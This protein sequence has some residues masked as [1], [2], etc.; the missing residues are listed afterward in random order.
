VT[1]IESRR[2][3][4]LGASALSVAGNARG[5]RKIPAK[6][7]VLTFDDAAK[8]HR[9]FVAPL[10]KDLNFRATFF[11]T[12]LWMDDGEHFMTWREI[13]EIHGMGFEIG[14]HA[15]THGNFS[16]PR[17]AS[18]LAGELALTENELHK[19]GVPRPVSFAYCGNNFGPEAFH[20]LR[21][22]GYR[23]ARR[24][25][26]PEAEYGKLQVGAVFE[27]RKHHPLLIPST[28]DAYPDWT[29]DHFERVL[30]QAREG[31]AVVLQFHGVPDPTH[32]WVNT[33]PENF[34]RYM[35]YLKEHEFHALALRDLEPF[36]DLANPPRDPMEQARYP[37][38]Q[39][40]KLALAAEVE[41][42]RADMPY[43]IASM[44]AHHYT[45]TEAAVVCG[46]PENEVEY[47]PASDPPLEGRPV[48]LPYPGGRHPRIGFLEGAID[49]MRGTK[50][51]I[52]LPWD[53]ASYVVVDLPEAIFANTGLLF[54][55][56]THVPT[57]WNDRNKTIEN[58]DWRRLENGGLTSRWLLPGGIALGASIEPHERRV[59]MELFLENGGSQALT[60]IRAQVCVLL[61]AASGFNA[62]TN[63]NKVL[64]KPIAGARNG[65]RWILTSWQDC[66]RVWANPPV[67]CF[68]SDPLLPD[69]APGQTVRVRGRLWFHE[70][71]D[72]GG[73]PSVA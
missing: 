14:N 55:A 50:A 73:E 7:V 9:S 16:T 42:T 31:Q 38:P 15:W 49:P 64:Q 30:T 63:D 57:I 11:V 36:V 62:Q 39:D 34:R 33:P 5:E 46:Q 43:W 26:P 47:V 58:V 41:A 35:T 17:G 71:K 2:K 28:G 22:R 13:A 18:H 19:V 53:P 70:G 20:V 66:G 69:C 61:K 65:D 59:D 45:R 67:P 12:H 72:I 54:L 27:P 56:H 6:T 37:S 21:D 25:L 60:S 8:S 10:L 1:F 4:L 48:V 51:S 24:G 44:R 3:F 52:F 68:H 29:F 40:G 32:P 23:F